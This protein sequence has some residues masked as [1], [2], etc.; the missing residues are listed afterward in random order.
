[1]SRTR[2]STV[3]F[4]APDAHGLADFYM[5]LLGYVKRAEEPDW[6]LIGPSFGGTGL[7]FET[8]R[9]YTPPVWPAAPGDQRMMLHIDIEVDDLAAETARAL[10][11][12]ARLADFQPQ[13]DVRVMLDPAGHPFCL[14]VHTHQS[15]RRRKNHPHEPPH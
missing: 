8:E 3:V 6:V 14:W 15:R 4:D 2:L 9:N 13:E 10:S 12:G 7:A 5:R 11:E 1:M